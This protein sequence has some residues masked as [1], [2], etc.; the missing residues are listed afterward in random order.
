MLKTMHLAGYSTLR[1]QK[2]AE[3]EA[4]RILGLFATLLCMEPFAGSGFPKGS[5]GSG[6]TPR[7]RDPL[8]GPAVKLHAVPTVAVEKT[9]VSHF[10]PGH[11]LQ[12][13]KPGLDAFRLHGGRGTPAT[14]TQD[15]AR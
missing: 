14:G 5:L 3:G 4:H 11:R 6:L 12:D 9:P 13:Q 8:N 2:P 1:G 15:H 7:H 10:L